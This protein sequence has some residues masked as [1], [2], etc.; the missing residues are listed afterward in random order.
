MY[1]Q[2]LPIILEPNIDELNR[3]VIC[4]VHNPKF[5]FPVQFNCAQ[6]SSVLRKKLDLNAHETLLLFA[7]TGDKHQLIRAN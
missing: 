3:G 5:L 1:P 4:A 6:V 7:R 2:K